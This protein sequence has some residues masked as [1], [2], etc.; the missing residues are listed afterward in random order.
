[1][2]TIAFGMGIDRSNIR[3]VVHAG[4]PKSLE[5]YQQETGRAGKNRAAGFLYLFYGPGDYR[6]W[7]FFAGQ[8]S[9]REVMTGKLKAI[10]DFCT[11]PQCR[12]KVLVDFWARLP[13]LLRSLDI[14]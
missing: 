2:A 14:V 5:H 6:L 1:M 13:N 4:M 7:N 8:S 3:F 12:H 11:R 9:E 10:Y